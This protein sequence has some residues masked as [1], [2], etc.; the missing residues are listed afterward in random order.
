MSTNPFVGTWRL[1]ANE[2]K[3]AQGEVSHPFGKEA[4][5]YLMYDPEGYMSVTIMAPNP[6]RF[7]SSDIRAGSPEDKRAAFD[8][9]IAYCRT[10]EVKGD[11]VVHHGE[12]SLF[13][14]WTGG[15]QERF[16][17]FSGNQLILCTPPLTVGGADLIMQLVW[18]RATPR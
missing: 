15:D 4:T 3:N 9:Y 17:Q 7:A 6:A 12:L 18:Q 2:T 10:Y 14:N 1:I 8:T 11:K 5:G 13:P 16:F